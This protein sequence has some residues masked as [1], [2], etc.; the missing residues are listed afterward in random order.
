MKKPSIKNQLQ[1]ANDKIAR[2][3]YD[4]LKAVGDDKTLQLY[5]EGLREDLSDYDR[6][7]K[8]EQL[9]AN[10]NKYGAYQSAGTE[11]RKRIKYMKRVRKEHVKLI[12][13]F[14][15]FIKLKNKLNKM[16]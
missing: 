1:E 9:F 11:A 7:I 14:E 16:W 8:D 2:I 13:M 3:F 6:D 4:T 10:E 5:L 12:K 15:Q